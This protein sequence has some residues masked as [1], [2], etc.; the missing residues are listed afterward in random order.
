MIDHKSL[1][2]QSIDLGERIASIEKDVYK[3]ADQEFNIGSPKQLQDIFYNQLK[4]PIIKKTPKGQPSTNE[5][6]MQELS[7]LHDLPKLILQYRNLSKLKNTY[8]DKL[9]TQ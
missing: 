3:L 4:L 5:D 8:T 6:V 2:K 7:L 1:Q 9:G